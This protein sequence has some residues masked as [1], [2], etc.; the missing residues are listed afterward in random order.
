MTGKTVVKEN[1]SKERVLGGGKRDSKLEAR[2]SRTASVILEHVP[3]ACRE[4]RVVVIHI[5]GKEEL[6]TYKPDIVQFKTQ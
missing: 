5:T 2:K 6:Q 3:K 4:I 1:R